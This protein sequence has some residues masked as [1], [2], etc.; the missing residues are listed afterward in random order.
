MVKQHAFY[1]NTPDIFKSGYTGYINISGNTIFKTFDKQ[2]EAL[3]TNITP[4]TIA[5]TSS[6]YTDWVSNEHK[7]L[8]YKLEDILLHPNEL[9]HANVLNQTFKLL[10]TN[11]E[12]IASRCMFYTNKIPT[13]YLG[14]FG[15]AVN[16]VRPSTTNGNYS[17]C[18]D[19]TYQFHNPSKPCYQYFPCRFASVS[20]ILVDSDVVTGIFGKA[21]HSKYGDIIL[22][23]LSATND[24]P[25]STY[26][27]TDT[28]IY[29]S[30]KNCIGLTTK[31]GN[32]YSIMF[33]SSSIL[34]NKIIK[35]E[36]AKTYKIETISTISN[37]M[38]TPLRDIVAADL[39]NSNILYVYDHDT[40]CIYQFDLHYIANDD[41][42]ITTPQLINMT[43]GVDT[44]SSQFYKFVNVKFIKCSN[45][46]VFIYDDVE[47][48]IM[49]FDKH[50]N[51]ISTTGNCGFYKHVPVGVTFRELQNEWYILCEDGYIVVLDVNFNVI[52]THQ[53][54]LT[55]KCVAIN[56]STEDTNIY[57]VTTKTSIYQK[58]F[59]N[60]KTIG[61]FNFNELGITNDTMRWWRSTYVAWNACEDLWGGSYMFPQ[62]MNTFNVLNVCVQNVGNMDEIWLF[63]NNG[64]L[65]WMQNKPSYHSLFAA[66]KQ[67]FM[68]YDNTQI[69]CGED[70]Y[71]QGLTYNK[72]IQKFIDTMNV[73]AESI[74]YRPLYNFNSLGEL[75]FDSLIY[76]TD[77]PTF[78]EQEIK[79]L[80]IYDND[81]L[82]VDVINR[83]L[84][85][86]YNFQQK[87]LDSTQALIN[88]SDYLLLQ[89]VTIE[90]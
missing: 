74:I 10:Y 9:V 81:I 58:M 61:Y 16:I 76:I 22:S 62:F 18:V 2:H 27:N 25:V 26:Y 71:I 34:F 30:L 56:A 48:T 47:N 80:K 3:D 28:T 79:N 88:N 87:L 8:P 24:T 46:N 29:D 70:E 54:D 44:L 43:G 11:L 89:N 57:Y 38:G 36:S 78:S 53:L 51:L 69:I 41:S 66:N 4:Q 84:T 39:S 17:Y 82:S 86:I 59:S 42:V 55:Q 83:V 77:K 72:I 60:H 21:N 13:N 19:N 31:N 90:I 68:Q 52:T 14:W 50:L 23:A 64:R 15:C 7:T 67:L 6:F 65:I 37:V 40:C 85:T 12:Y 33:T 75:I 32:S 49:V 5:Y 73:L 35:G 1:I 63:V 45:E 20:G